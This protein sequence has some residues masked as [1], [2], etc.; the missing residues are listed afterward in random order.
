MRGRGCQLVEGKSLRTITD[1]YFRMAGFT[2]NISL[3]SDSP[4]TVREFVRAG[5]GLSLVPSITWSCVRGRQIAL[6]PIASPHCH[7]FINLSWRPGPSRSAAVLLRDYLSERFCACA[8]AQNAAR[9]A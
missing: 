1:V 8:L 6:R 7:R 2:P 3:E 9:P 4:Q 5:V